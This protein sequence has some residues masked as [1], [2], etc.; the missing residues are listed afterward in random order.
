MNYSFNMKIFTVMFGIFVIAYAT[1]FVGTRKN[2]FPLI[3]NVQCTVISKRIE[4]F[5]PLPDSVDHKMHFVLFQT[6]VAGAIELEVSVFQYH[7]LVEGQEL[8]IS[9]QGRKLK[10]FMMW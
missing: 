3:T 2:T 4:S 5:K 7:I 8:R 10:K 1:K 9:Y 6:Y